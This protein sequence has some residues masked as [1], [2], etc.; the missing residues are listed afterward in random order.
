LARVAPEKTILHRPANVSFVKQTDEVRLKMHY[1]Q[2]NIGDYQS[3]TA[4]L[5]PLEDVAYQRM[6]DWCY[7]HERPLPDDIEQISKLIRMRSHCDC[8]TSVLHEF[9]VRT[10]EGWW[11]ERIGKEIEKTGDKSRKASESAKARWHKGKDD[12]NA[13]PAQSERNATHNTLPKTQD[14]KHTTQKKAPA[15][16]CPT[17]VDPKVWSDWLEIRKAKN[18][19]LTV[20]AWGQLEIERQKAGLTTEAMIKECCLRGWGA[21]KASWWEKDGKEKV[22]FET[23]GDRNAKVISGLTRGLLGSGKNVKLLGN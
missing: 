13:L 2:F 1:Y 6:L 10:P 15:V 18:L 9:F 4:H 12:A 14:T 23:Q 20:T 19:P 11:K 22:A 5:E 21:F 8:I 3:H 16:L 7:L 17:G